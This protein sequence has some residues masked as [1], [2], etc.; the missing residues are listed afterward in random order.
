M[1]EEWFGICAKGPTSPRGL[2]HLF[3][4][5]AYYALQEV[6]QIKPYATGMTAQAIDAYFGNIELTN[7]VLR[8]RG[9]GG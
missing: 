5:A 4:R 3:P 2:Y 7:A 6:H 8:A 9:D 1:N